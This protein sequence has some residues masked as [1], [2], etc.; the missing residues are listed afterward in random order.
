MTFKEIRKKLNMVHLFGFKKV[1]GRYERT[2]NKGDCFTKQTISKNGII[3]TKDLFGLLTYLVE[4]QNDELEQF[5]ISR[6]EVENG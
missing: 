3:S 2:I 6:K 4:K 5:T 1:L